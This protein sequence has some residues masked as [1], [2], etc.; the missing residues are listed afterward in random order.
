MADP[1]KLIEQKRRQLVE[2]LEKRQADL[3]A[4]QGAIQVLDELLAE[5]RKNEDQISS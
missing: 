2:E 5:L 3:Y 4:M 1:I